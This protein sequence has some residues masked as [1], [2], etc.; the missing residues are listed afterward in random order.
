MLSKITKN[1]IDFDDKD[2]NEKNSIEPIVSERQKME[3]FTSGLK[4]IQI[5]Y[6]KKYDMASL[7]HW[8]AQL[9]GLNQVI[10]NPY[11]HK[12]KFFSNDIIKVI[13]DWIHSTTPQNRDI[14]FDFLENIVGE[15]KNIP[16]WHA[17][18]GIRYKMSIQVLWYVFLEV[19]IKKVFL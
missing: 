19:R 5:V 12:V 3:F 6:D 13:A 11:N 18:C 7:S 9:L 17:H 8:G 4:E 1:L 2:I 15:V 14:K 10:I 16:L